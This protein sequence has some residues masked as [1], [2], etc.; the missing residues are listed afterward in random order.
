VT[1]GKAAF[2]YGFI[3][4]SAKLPCTRGSW[5]AFWMMPQGSERWPD[6]GEIDILEHVGSHA[7]RRHANLHTKLFNHTQQQWTGRAEAARDGLQ[8]LPPLPA[9]LDTTGDH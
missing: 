3:E 1:Q 2:K 4:A 7:G 9:K 5:P 6:G 8:C